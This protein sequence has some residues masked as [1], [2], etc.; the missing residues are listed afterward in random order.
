MHI[1]GEILLKQ[2]PNLSKQSVAKVAGHNTAQCVVVLDS[3]GECSFLIGDMKIHEEISPKMVFQPFK[4]TLVHSTIRFY[5]QV[6]KHESLIKAA[7]LVVMDGNLSIEAMDKLLGITE[8]HN[9]P[10]K[11]I[12]KEVLNITKQI[13]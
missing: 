9:I 3:T 1:P 12:A 4:V 6:E 10:G 11:S 7:P 13:K 5:K 2:I 8:Q